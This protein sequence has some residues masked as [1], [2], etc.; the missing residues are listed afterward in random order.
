MSNRKKSS[1]KHVPRTWLRPSVPLAARLGAMAG[2]ALIV[3]AICIAYFP[4]FS[5]GFIL[6]DDKLLTD[7]AQIQD[8]DG[9]YQFW[10]T[11]KAYDYWPVTNS[12][13]WMEWRLWEMNPAGYHVANLA[14]HAAASL[15]IW[16]ILRKLSIPG[17]FLAA[18]I[19]AV[20]PVNV[21]SAAWIA[22]RKDDLAIVFFL[23]SMLWY[24]KALMP[25]VNAGM[26]PARSQGGPWE[27]AKKH[28]PLSTLH[29]PLWY[30]LSLLAFAL[31]ML[32]KGSIAILPLLLLG[33][34]WWLRPLTRRDLARI[35]PFFLIAAA[36]AAVNVW[37]QTHLGGSIRTVAFPVRILEAGAVVWFYLYKAILPIDLVFIYPLW[38]I[39]PGDFRWWLPLAATL[40]VTA[41]LWLY[42]KG[43]SRPILFAWGFFCVAL[44][45]VMGFT[46]VGFM[47]HS[48]VADHYQHIAVIGVIA[49]AAAGWSVWRGRLRAAFAR[50]AYVMAIIAVL[51]LLLLSRLLNG[52]YCDAAELYRLT[53]KKNPGCWLIHNN[54]GVLL[55]DA[56]RRQ[57][58]IA[59]YKETLR[60]NPDYSEAHNNMGNALGALGQWQD[61]LGCYHKALELVPEHPLTLN[62]LGYALGSLGRFPEAIEQYQKALKIQ[63]NIGG[64]HDNMAFTLLQMG[65]QPEA[66]EQYQEAINLEPKNPEYRAH[67]GFALT[68][69][70]RLSEA[71]KQC[72]EALRLSPNHPDAHFNLGMALTMT[73]Q[74]LEAIEHYSWSLRYKPDKPQVYYQLSI[75]YALVRRFSEAET[76]AQRAMDLARSQGH[77]ALARQAGD[78][79]NSIRAGLPDLKNIPPSSK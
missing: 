63:P 70:G 20:H 77:T 68:Q 41:V 69:A 39:D 5:S 64:I 66:L 38:S 62:N 2:A 24:L 54:L 3:I 27:R 33:I 50:T 26:A 79:L 16:L 56:G 61:A 28:S 17:A 10:L 32:S 9:L 30:W 44:L 47:K 58:A 36:L 55:A 37:F 76:A 67:Y 29:S 60:L 46:D 57:E 40:A 18:L 45:P 34:V 51:A 49:L 35:A 11:T 25:T 65:R 52:L 6:D 59:Q 21:E 43:W 15:L 72:R 1:D 7:N 78:L 19:F 48:L 42:R 4:A 14:L 73:G 53:L 31:G 22:Q 13:L 12:T 74:H 71:I 75:S 23:L 8:S